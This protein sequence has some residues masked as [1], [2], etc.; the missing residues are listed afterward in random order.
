MTLHE[1]IKNVL[2]NFG[3][4][5]V[6]EITDKINS[7]R[8]YKRK[9]GQRINTNQI[10]AR[11]AK[12]PELFVIDQDNKVTLRNYS[13]ISLKLTIDKIADTLYL[14][15][16][17]IAHLNEL[18]LPVFAIYL[19]YSDPDGLLRN[20]E[21]GEKTST[22]IFASNLV[23]DL[24]T[25]NETK[26]FKG[27]LTKPIEAFN[28]L[29]ELLKLNIVMNILSGST[30]MRSA[31]YFTER[32][33]SDEYESFDEYL[34][35]ELDLKTMFESVGDY[36][37]RFK[38]YA[39]W[40]VPENDFKNYFNKL[41]NEF[42]WKKRFQSLQSTPVS[43]AKLISAIIHSDEFKLDKEYVFIDPFFGK[44]TL[45]A[46]ICLQNTARNVSVYGG[47]LNENAITIAKL[48][49][50]VNG[51]KQPEIRR[52]NAFTE[53]ATLSSVADWFICDPPM[54]QKINLDIA[55]FGGYGSP[56]NV[57]EAVINMALYHIHENGKACIVVPESFIFSST[58]STMALRKKLV[59]SNFL[60]GIISLP[61]GLY[62]PYSSV[63]TSL[64]IIDKSR[65]R[66]KNNLIFIY[67]ASKVMPVELETVIPEI[68][69]RYSE[70][71]TDFFL[72]HFY[73]NNERVAEQN[74]DYSIQKFTQP[75]Y[76]DSSLQNYL[77]VG[78]L[79]PIMH[80][81]VNNTQS[82]ILSGNAIKKED[83]SSIAGIPYV[84]ISDLNNDPFNCYLREDR[85][86]TYLESTENMNPRFLKKGS[87]LV[88]KAGNNLK[89]TI[90]NGET[91][92]LFS[93]SIMGFNLDTSR[94]NPR[95]FILQL[96]EKYFIEQLTKIKRGVTILSFK[97]EDFL[98]LLVCVPS[99][100]EQDKILK[101][102]DELGNKGNFN[103]EEISNLIGE[104]KHKAKGPLGG[105]KASVTRLEN[106]LKRKQV[107][108]EK[109]IPND[110][111]YNLLTD[112]KW[113][114]F[115]QYSLEETFKRLHLHIDRID[116]YFK[117]AIRFAM[118][119]DED[120]DVEP[121][122]LFELI[123]SIVIPSNQYNFQ[124]L[125]EIG[126]H[127][128]NL[129][130]QAN[131]DR[132]LTIFELLLD[133]AFTHGF[134]SNPDKNSK[135]GISWIIRTGQDLRQK[136][137]VITV[138]NNGAPAK[139]LTLEK[140]ITNGHTTNVEHGGLGM[141]G[142]FI[143]KALLQMGGELITVEDISEKTGEYNIQFKFKL[144]FSE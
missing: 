100:E 97:P 16:A 18:L 136:E 99:I 5:P 33:T 7:H 130:V 14:S 76:P 128:K 15:S 41:I 132:L 79:L 40:N 88:S 82:S 84:Q 120:V 125:G 111:A 103:K 54:M 29:E 47:D 139:G 78:D 127:S 38:E 85:I 69:E 45:M 129:K 86:K 96:H 58:K 57:I 19:K 23:E 104:L 20:V 13:L 94:I 93:S 98:N 39:S 59:D 3:K 51:L 31:K 35:D 116:D 134:K 75:L 122:V 67:D 37:K 27:L 73:I 133:N 46:E 66:L 22:D 143:H 140:F 115:K 141:G 72:P 64:I 65:K 121:I 1:A 32:K 21:K 77:K 109:I 12:Y 81:G 101:D 137:I 83:L 118:L 43:I 95:F 49:F 91:D 10:S 55:L 80:S 131:K 87:I 60:D 117:K 90:Y 2:L 119:G 53:W 28:N 56:K 34:N 26:Q 44:G 138:E 113:E 102:K 107:S 8:L 48:L 123:N 24:N 6:K 89:P 30:H 71:N 62:A 50:A 114:D 61:P 9:D 4:L 63:K 106:F 108:G 36:Q 11:I 70:K 142:A 92:I 110:I 25:I 124:I 52:A 112:Q 126:K 144:L 42:S 105:I 68:R 135:V 17:N 74:Y